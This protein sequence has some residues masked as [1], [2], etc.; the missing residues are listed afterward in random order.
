MD[1]EGRPGLPMT[2][3]IVGDSLIAETGEYES[4]LRESVM[5]SV[6]TASVLQNGVL[7]GTLVAT[8]RT[9][10]GDEVVGGTLRATRVSN[11]T[12]RISVGPEGSLGPGPEALPVCRSELT[13]GAGDRGGPLYP[14]SSRG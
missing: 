3:S 9:T 12:T 4:V 11:Q 6:R 1:L 14:A 2:V 10:D 7:T 8:Y 13:P 5:V